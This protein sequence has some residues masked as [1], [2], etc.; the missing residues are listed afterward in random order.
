MFSVKREKMKKKR[1]RQGTR[2]EVGEGRKQEREGGKWN[3]NEDGR[4]GRIEDEA[5]T[6][7]YVVNH[8]SDVLIPKKTNIEFL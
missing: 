3:G 8:I 6:F 5:C 4:G 2:K 1:G 7:F